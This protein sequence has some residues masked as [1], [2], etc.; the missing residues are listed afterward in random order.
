MNTRRVRALCEEHAHRMLKRMIERRNGGFAW[1]E[2]HNSRFELTKLILMDFIRSKTANHPLLI[3]H[4]RTFTPQQTHR[5][6]GVI[7]DQELRWNHQVDHD[8]FRYLKGTVDYKLTFGPSPS[9]STELF[10]TYSDA[11]YGG[12]KDTGQSTGAYIVKIGTGAISSS[13]KLQTMVTLSTTEAEYIAAVS[14]GQ[15]ILWLR[16]L[17]SELGYKSKGASTLYI[18]NQS[19]VAV[20]KNP[21]HHGRI[22]H[23]DL[24]FYWLR[25]VVD[26]GQISVVHFPTAAMPADLLTKS[27]A[28]VK[29][30]LGR[31]MLGLVQ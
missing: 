27:L 17:F 2:S 5:F 22:K 10:Q 9:T 30:E 19:A 13:S 11:D 29:V 16:N 31:D 12:D 1:S 20:A 15:E 25:D 26:S 23:L 28:R 4:S 8:L 3:L 18:D 7:M 14:A 21:E 6:I 24:R